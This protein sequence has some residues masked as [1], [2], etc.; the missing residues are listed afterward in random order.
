MKAAVST[1]F[2]I[3]LAGGHMKYKIWK[4]QGLWPV[5]NADRIFPSD[6]CHYLFLL[7]GDLGHFYRQMSPKVF[8][9][10]PHRPTSPAQ[11][12]SWTLSFAIISLLL[13]TLQRARPSVITP[14][15]MLSLREIVVS[16]PMWGGVGLSGCYLT[17]N[18]VMELSSTDCNLK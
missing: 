9:D 11:N 16:Q 15:K 13:L 2:Y 18:S 3:R 5:L 17:V 8:S 1:A 6:H 10:P 12:E 4:S 7:G 14:W